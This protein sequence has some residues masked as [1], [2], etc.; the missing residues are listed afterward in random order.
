MLAEGPRARRML[1]RF[2]PPCM[3]S[4][5]ATCMSATCMGLTRF[6]ARGAC[7]CWNERVARVIAVMRICGS[8]RGSLGHR[9][10]RVERMA[11]S[12]EFALCEGL[13]ES[14]VES[15]SC[16]IRDCVLLLYVLIISL[17]TVCASRRIAVK[18]TP[19][20]LCHGMSLLFDEL[21]YQ[22]PA[23]SP[24]DGST[25]NNKA[26]RKAGYASRISH[27]Y[28]TKDDSRTLITSVQ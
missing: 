9:R 16:E 23:I 6:D 19:L 15:E 11:L 21:I 14:S 5:R 12:A 1:G 2:G 22:K 3:M 4:P 20:D 24:C 17:R 25:K 28:S 8:S 13:R 18:L 7:E 26:Y 27:D 10:K